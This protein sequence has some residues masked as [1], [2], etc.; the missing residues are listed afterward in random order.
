MGG[1]SGVPASG[2]PLAKVRHDR[3][4]NGRERNAYEE[5]LAG[6]R[7]TARS[8]TGSVNAEPIATSDRDDG[9]DG[10]G[11]SSLASWLAW[12]LGMPAVQLDLYLTS[13][14]ELSGARLCRVKTVMLC[15][16]V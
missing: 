15:S 16:G 9:V 12:Q 6:V 2:R 10:G 14:R 13:N 11:K 1:R 3:S 4:I 7:R 5:A 8:R